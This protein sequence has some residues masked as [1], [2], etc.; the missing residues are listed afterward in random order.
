MKSLNI[1]IPLSIAYDMSEH[2]KLNPQYMTS[3]LSTNLDNVDSVVDKHI[4]G[5]NYHYTFKV[6]ADLHQQLK[7]KSVQTDISMND[8]VGRLI[9]CYYEGEQHG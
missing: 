7:I 9:C 8:L 2:G 6:P 1:K 5:L 4:E 3:F